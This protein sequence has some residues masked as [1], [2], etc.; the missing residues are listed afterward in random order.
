MASEITYIVG[1]KA[2][3]THTVIFLHDCDSDCEEFASEFFVS[4]ASEPGTLK[5]ISPHIRW[6]FP[7]APILMSARFGIHLSQ[8]FDMW[9]L[10]N[11]MERPELQYHG[12]HQSIN[13]ILGVIRKE[14][15]LVPRDKI[16]LA[17]IS[18]GFATTIAT[19]LADASKGFAGLIG[20]CGWMP[21]LLNDG[22]EGFK[23]P[24]NSKVVDSTPIFLG[25]SAD[26]DIVP[27]ENGRELRDILQSRGFEVEWREYNEGGHWVNEPQGVDDMVQFLSKH[28]AINES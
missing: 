13:R 7:S 24:E 27:I 26:D 5:D 9:S 15:E 19:F 17:G 16:F 18:Q 3:H 10:D 6:V 25:H 8:W 12:L 11:P 2:E 1:P 4:E 21:A 28:M 20:L 23:G 22:R 14:E